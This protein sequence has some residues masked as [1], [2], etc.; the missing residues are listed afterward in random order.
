MVQKDCTKERIEMHT[1]MENIVTVEHKS[2]FICTSVSAGTV[3]V[4]AGA[5][6][7]HCQKNRKAN[8]E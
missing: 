7:V 2:G 4:D 6:S 5:V 1:S 8:P 3:S